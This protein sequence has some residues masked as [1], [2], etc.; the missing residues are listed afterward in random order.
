M[1]DLHDPDDFIGVMIAIALVAVAAL[2]LAITYLEGMN[3]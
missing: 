2:Y 3:K 1:K